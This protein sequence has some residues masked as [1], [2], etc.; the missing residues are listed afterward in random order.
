MLSTQHLVTEN[1]WLMN[2][3][4]KSSSRKLLSFQQKYDRNQQIFRIKNSSLTIL[5]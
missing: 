4:N 2:K 5:I 3:E 1:N